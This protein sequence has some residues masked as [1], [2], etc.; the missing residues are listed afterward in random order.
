V[1]IEDL[2]QLLGEALGTHQV[3]HAQAAARHLVLVGRADATA[4]G[5]DL[6]GALGRFARDVQRL[7]MRHDER[8]GFRNLD[9]RFGVNTGG[10]ELVEFLDQRIG[11]EDD[12]VADVAGDAV[13][14]DARGHEVQHGLLAAD[15][16]RVAGVVAALETHHAPG[17]VGQPID[18]LAFALVAPLGADDNDVAS[19]AVRHVSLPSRFQ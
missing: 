16:Q 11:R 1:I 17:V 6:V 9:A 8:A 14:Q 10:L 19:G 4:G 12:A 7:V 15:D 18:D 3:L 13:A 2:G 5:A